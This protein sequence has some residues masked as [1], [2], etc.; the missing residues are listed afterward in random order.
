MTIKV[1]GIDISLNDLMHYEYN[2]EDYGYLIEQLNLYADL[3]YQRNYLWKIYLEK[4]FPMNFL[5]IQISEINL[6]QV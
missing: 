6:N 5:F 1:E 3:A 2:Q 4:I